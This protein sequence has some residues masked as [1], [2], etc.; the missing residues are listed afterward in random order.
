M[1]LAI[2]GLIGVAIAIVAAAAVLTVERIA[3][4]RKRRR[5]ARAIRVGWMPLDPSV[6]E[7][8]LR[9]RCESGITPRGSRRGAGLRR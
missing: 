2:I 8:E 4:E 3:W 9:I 5:R 7:I 6:D 1:S